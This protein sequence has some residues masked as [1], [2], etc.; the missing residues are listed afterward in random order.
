MTECVF[1]CVSE[2][3]SK[4]RDLSNK[5][6]KGICFPFHCQ[7]NGKIRGV[8]T[9]SVKLELNHNNHYGRPHTNTRTI[10]HSHTH[11]HKWRYNILPA[12]RPYISLVKTGIVDTLVNSYRCKN[13]N[14]FFQRPSKTST[15]HLI[16]LR[17]QNLSVHV[18]IYG[19]VFMPLFFFRTDSADSSV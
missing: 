7:E 10:I 9:L 19:C 12:A 3:E 14:A 8:M 6:Q 17:T 1:L 11:T 2:C 5:R 4:R 13:T 15:T 16:I 18:C